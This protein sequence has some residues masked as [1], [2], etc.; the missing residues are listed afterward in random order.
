MLVLLSAVTDLESVSLNT[1]AEFLGLKVRTKLSHFPNFT[2]STL[3]PPHSIAWH[4]ER[5][6]F[7]LGPQTGDTGSVSHSIHESL[8][9]A[10]PSFSMT[11]EKFSEVSF[12]PNFVW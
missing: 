5:Y 2:S 3:N 1:N 7:Q 10:S 4:I 8:P 6:V 12:L 11:I 9:L